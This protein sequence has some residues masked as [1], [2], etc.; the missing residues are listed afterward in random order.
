MEIVV[1][2]GK[3]GT[4]KTFIASNLAYYLKANGEKVVAVDADAEA[5]D[6]LLALGGSKKNIFS[7]HVSLSRKARIIYEKCTGCL[8]CANACKFY[9]IDVADGKPRIIEEY[10]EGCNACN[11]VCPAKCIELYVKETG[12]VKCDISQY[13]IPVITA[14]LEVGGRNSG[15]LVY[16][17]REEA[18]KLSREMNA[19]HIII[20]AAAG[21]GCPVISSLAGA[22]I[23][24]VIVEPTPPSISGAKRLLE[25]AEK[26]KIKPYIIINRYD[27]YPE[28]AVKEIME[29]RC[30]VI[31]KI[32]YD[33]TVVE[34]YVNMKPILL[35]NPNSKASKSLLEALD[36]FLRVLK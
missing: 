32:P 23:L 3:G 11:I 7:N 1:A 15:D 29:M 19:K 16:M 27:A 5:P 36:Y 13:E 6:L 8:S 28:D 24:I 35:Y 12:I 10:C 34:A 25:V 31:G 18:H 26:M 9:A 14:D 2:S 20:D 17:A 4:G 21:I 30:E 22:Q 33:K